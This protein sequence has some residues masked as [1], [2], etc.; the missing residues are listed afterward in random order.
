MGKKDTERRV[1]TREFKAEAAALAEKHKKPA[2]RVAADLGI[3]EKVLY[4]WIQRARESAGTGLPPFPGH[5]R[6]RDEELARLRKEAKAL[7]EAS[8]TSFPLKS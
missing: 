5:G 3:N 4:R 8:E 7:R 2:S 6:P 1:Y